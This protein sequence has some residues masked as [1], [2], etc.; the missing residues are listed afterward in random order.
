MTIRGAAAIVGIAEL[1]TRRTYPGRS[2]QGL[3]AEVVRQAL[4]DAHLRKQDIDGVIT[5]GGDV[6]PAD[7]I[8]TLG[9][10]PCFATGVS[11]HGASACT[12]VSM[13]AAA[14]HGGL[15][16]N[17]LIVMANARTGDAAPGGPSAPSMTRE[18]E[19]PFGPA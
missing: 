2:L 13:A 6:Y 15:A 17:I 4:E 12:A 7:V 16:Q 10:R 9:L 18:F 1:P 8:E 14:I 3:H 19:A 11:M 5:E